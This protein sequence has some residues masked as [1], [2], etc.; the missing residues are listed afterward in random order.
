MRIFKALAHFCKDIFQFSDFPIAMTS[1]I[2][3]ADVIKIIMESSLFFFRIIIFTIMYH[4]IK[5][6]GSIIIISDFM[7]GLLLEQP[8]VFQYIPNTLDGIGLS[9]GQCSNRNTIEN[10]NE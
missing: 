3:N 8:P 7:R 5:F 2:K 9:V 4:S 1:Y 6:D 10:K